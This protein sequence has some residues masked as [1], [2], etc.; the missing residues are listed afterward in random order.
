MDSH[1]RGN[2]EFS[3]EVGKLLLGWGMKGGHYSG[4]QILE[5]SLYGA[6]TFVLMLD[7]KQEIEDLKQELN[8]H[9]AKPKAPDDEIREQAARHIRSRASNPYIEGLP[10][11]LID[12][13]MLQ[14]DWTK[15]NLLLKEIAD[16]LSP[17]SHPEH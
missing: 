3:K 16:I 8:D 9:L 10:T 1:N 2:D 5:R 13:E 4:W 6:A 17:V 7:G 15:M 14:V 12:H 11:S